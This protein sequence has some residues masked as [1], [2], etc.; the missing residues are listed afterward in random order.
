VVPAP[1]E[2]PQGGKDLGRALPIEFV[3]LSRTES[4]GLNDG[5]VDGSPEKCL[6]PGRVGGGRQTAPTFPERQNNGFRQESPDALRKGKE[7]VSELVDGMLTVV[8]RCLR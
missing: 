6:A 1:K 4:Y 7:L 3:E 8:M 5:L 2:N